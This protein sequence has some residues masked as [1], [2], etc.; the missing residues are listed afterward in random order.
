MSF[1]DG[2]KSN[3]ITIIKKADESISNDDVLHN[4][5]ELF[6]SGEANKIYTGRF[7]LYNT[8]DNL[9]GVKYK[10][11]LP[12]G[13]TIRGSSPVTEPGTSDLSLDRAIGGGNG[14]QQIHSQD[15]RI[16]MGST[17]GLIRLQWAQNVIDPSTTTINKGSSIILSRS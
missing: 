17:S 15:I 6:F 2:G 4:D 12:V 3:L 1:F 8:K 16:I 7:L 10:F 14:T 5:N 9:V 11:T 13:A